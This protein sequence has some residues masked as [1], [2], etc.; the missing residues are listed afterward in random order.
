MSDV[1]FATKTPE[2]YRAEAAKH[3]QEERDSFERCDTDG[4]VSQWASGMT[5]KK[6]DALA[7]LAENDGYMETMALFYNGQFVSAHQGFSQYGEWWRLT[8]EGESQYGKAFYSP[9]KA[10]NGIARDRAKGFT[11]GTIR[12]RGYVDI[13]APASAKGL[14][15]AFQAYVGTFPVV[16]DL[17]EGKFE[18]LAADGALARLEAE[19]A[20]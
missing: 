17:R 7:R 5:A 19:Q 3:R 10:K 13:K 15:G 16:E 18:V 12:V 11:Y 20:A 4:F 2:E 9:S 1:T 6:Y 14:A 8:P